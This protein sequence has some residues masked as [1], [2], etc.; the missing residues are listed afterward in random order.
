MRT[1]CFVLLLLTSFAF[2]QTQTPAAQNPATPQKAAPAAQTGAKPSTGPEIQKAEPAESA[3]PADAP[4]ITIGGVCDKPAA[5]A[6][7][8]KTVI[9]RAQFE[10]MLSMVAPSRAGSPSQL[11]PAAR[12]NMATQYSQLL[13]VAGAAEKQGI[14]NTPQAQELLKVARMQA[15]AQA[16]T[17]ELQ[18]KSE[19]TEA[20]IQKFYN[21]NAA[22]LEQATLDR[23]FVPKP[24]GSAEKKTETGTKAATPTKPGTKGAAAST[25]LAAKAENLHQRAVAGEPFDKLQ[26]EA[27]AGSNFPNAPETKMVVQKGTLPLEQESVFNLKPGEVSQVFTEPSG[28]FIYKMVSKGPIPLEQVK[29][30]IRQRLTQEK[31]QAAMET[32][33][34]ASKPVLNEQYFGPPPAAQR[35]PGEARPASESTKPQQGATE[36]PK[37]DSQPK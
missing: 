8:C 18:Q 27:L 21:D 34:N 16:Y 9:T 2:A 19:P 30:E 37:P 28:A 31:M 7:D 6:A 13:T 23:I 4:V 3:V 35:N 29:D 11:P 20:E 10:Q 15:L 25:T 32:V 26:K 5:N 22:K 36:R 14:E 24:A 17:R 33:L 1:R 12:R